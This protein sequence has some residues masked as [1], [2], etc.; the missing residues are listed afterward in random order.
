MAMPVQLESNKAMRP[1]D[2]LLQRSLV[3]AA[4]IMNKGAFRLVT[5]AVRRLSATGAQTI[6]RIAPDSLFSFPLG[7]NYWSKA[8]FLRADYEP[9][10]RYLLKA[11]RDVPY[12][13][14]DCG[15]NYG[16]WSI[17]VSGREF[18]A[19]PAI[20]IEAAQ[21]NLPQLEANA[22]INQNRFK[23]LHRAVF[24]KSGETL[25]IYG[26]N[27]FGLTVAPGNSEKRTTLQQFKVETV[28]LDNAA[29]KLAVAASTPVIVKLDV[30]GAETDAIAGASSLLKRD[31]LFLYEDERADRQH[32]IS[33]HL[34]LDKGLALYVIWP[35]RM[36]TPVSSLV[37]IADAKSKGVFN[38]AATPRLSRWNS[39]IQDSSRYEQENI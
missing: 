21:S 33:R 23:V 30:E 38:F 25:S 29:G 22:R 17:Q 8:V 34:L 24:S 6:V 7:D 9:E 37:D 12:G 32:E 18:G 14:I 15:A 11:V 28:T 1:L 36:A 3:A 39:I 16:Y 20:A 19:H 27:H 2:R 4:G 26:K 13:F 31:V 10:L 35:D 5:G